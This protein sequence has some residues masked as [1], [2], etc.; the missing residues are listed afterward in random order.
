MRAMNPMSMRRIVLRMVIATGDGG[1]I[2][3][4]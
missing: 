4:I 3:E 1:K 2:K